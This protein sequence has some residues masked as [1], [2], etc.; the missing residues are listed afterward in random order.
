MGLFGLIPFVFG[1]VSAQSSSSLAIEGGGLSIKQPD[2]VSATARA[3]TVSGRHATISTAISGSVLLLQASDNS[4]ASQGTLGAEVAL[5]RWSS[6]RVQASGSATTFGALADNNG[7][8]RDGFVRP[9]FVR[10][11]F[12]L[13]STFG[14]GAARRDSMRFHSLSWDAGAWAEHGRLTGMFTFRQSFSNDFPLL[15]AS[16]IFLVRPSRHYSVRDVEGVVTAR[17]WR[18]DLQTV[19]AWRAGFAATKGHGGSLLG[20]ATMHLSSHVALVVNGGKQLA[21]VLSGVPAA[22]IA[23]ASLRL[24]FPRT[25]SRSVDHVATRDSSNVARETSPFATRI[26][27]HV[28]GGASA[29]V[30]VDAPTNARVELSGTFNDWAVVTVP[31]T[32]NGFELTVELPSGTHR[33]AIRINGGAWRAP[34]GLARIKDDLGGEAGLV[35][36]P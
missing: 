36:V 20:A 32:T 25:I 26:T 14:A 24:S 2:H 7:S 29:T 9:Q 35:V 27:R 13:F 3:F 15:E 4:T 22:T 21:D 8:S 28:A 5:P 34:T 11:N 30:R 6:W 18:F 31:H 12:G 16:N 33:I 10:E 23:G 1:T 19:C 17:L